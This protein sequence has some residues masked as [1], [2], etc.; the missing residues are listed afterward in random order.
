VWIVSGKR[1]FKALEANISTQETNSDKPSREGIVIRSTSGHM[2][3]SEGTNIWICQ[4]RGRLKKGPRES[5]TLAVVGDR[6]RFSVQD[7]TSTPPS[8]VVEEVL[9]RRNKISRLAARRSGGNVEQVLMANLDQVVAVQSVQDPTP[10]SSFVDRLLV[11][12]ERFGVSGVLVL[13][14]WDL[15]PFDHNRERWQYYTD[16]GYR[17]IFTSAVSG[18]GVEDFREV[19]ADRISLLIGASGVGKSTLLNAIE[20]ELGLRVNEVTGKTGLGRHTTTRTELFPL[21]TGGFIADSPGIRGFDPWDID[22]LDLRDYF[23]DFAE[24]QLEC[25]Y[26]TC[27]HRH[28]PGCGVKLNVAKGKIPGWRLE[29]YLALLVDLEERKEKLGFRKTDS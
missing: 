19:L 3:I 23:P 6:V 11:A 17:V 2:Q 24:G 9:P 20:P 16:L 5:Q 25:R 15:V 1:D 28:E 14:K 12:A 22:P 4:I 29:A 10:Q 7:E 21:A 8:G 27:L 18:L 13:N 26:R